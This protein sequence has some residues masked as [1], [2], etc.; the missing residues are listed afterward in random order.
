MILT[1][2]VT[3][4]FTLKIFSYGF[5]GLICFTVI[6]MTWEPM[7]I[8]G[9]EGEEDVDEEMMGFP[10]MQCTGRGRKHHLTLNEIKERVPKRAKVLYSDIIYATS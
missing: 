2:E 4:T 1:Y 9:G 6:S 3:A 8:M 7:D 10:L 5:N